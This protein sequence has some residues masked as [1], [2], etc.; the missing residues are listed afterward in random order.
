MKKLLTLAFSLTVLIAGAQ[1]YLSFYN[2]NHINQN[3]MVN[4]AS[5]HDYKF[6]I[7][8]PGIGGF[9]SNVN[10]GSLDLD[11]LENGADINEKLDDAISG[12]K[13]NDRF[14]FNE[15]I[16]GIF[17]GFAT[18]DKGYWTVAAQQITDFNMII[19]SELIKFLY[20]GN[21]GSGYLGN[22]LT[23]DNFNVEISVRNEY[24]VGYQHK[25]ND[26]LILGGRYKYISGVANTYVDKFKFD[27]YSDV[28]IW[29]INTDILINTSGSDIVNN[30]DP[31]GVATNS[32]FSRNSGMGFDIGAYYKINEKFDVSVSALNMGWI[33]WRKDLVG[34]KSKGSFEFEGL[35]ISYPGNDFDAGINNLVDS[36]GNAFNFE[37]VAIESYTTALPSQFIVSGQFYATEKHV[38]GLIYQG[39]L[40]NKTLYHNYG[41]M[42][43]GRYSKWI[44]IM[45]GYSIQNSVQ[46][47]ISLG[48][49]VRLGPVQI[50]A[51]TD[52]TF[53][54][55]NPTAVNS[56]NIRAGL[57][58][59]FTEK[60]KILKE[61][62]EKL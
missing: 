32:L 23:M 7:G 60:P 12:L 45:A 54:I 47:N 41:I 44:N 9:T 3:L 25:V 39:S 10:S 8:I 1:S 51:L 58:L 56:V 55:L 30:F 40:W 16:D 27:L 28:D 18:G 36:L 13:P 31:Q 2:F 61:K 20:Y 42:Y 19:P 34:L 22:T 26:K 35:N 15:T 37:E 33:K 59:S 50:Y 14:N 38:F 46:N 49:S 43:N 52:N 62:E 57:T 53:G 48:F 17:V 21:V 11:G 4:P 6:V 5:P 24:S 29:T